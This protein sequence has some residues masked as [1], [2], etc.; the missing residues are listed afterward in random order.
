[1]NAAH[2][3]Q[4]FDLKAPYPQL[5]TRM[6]DHS[7]A[8]WGINTF[9]PKQTNGLWNLPILSFSEGPHWQ[10]MD[11][12]E[13]TLENLG[14][15]VNKIFGQDG[16]DSARTE[17]KKNKGNDEQVWELFNEDNYCWFGDG[18]SGL[19][20]IYTDGFGWGLQN[21]D[22][23]LLAD[24]WGALQ[25]VNQSTTQ[26]DALV[27]VKNAVCDRKEKDQAA[28]IGKTIADLL[29]NGLVFAAKFEGGLA[30]SVS[31]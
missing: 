3:G 19:V 18:L 24:I 26:H 29:I 22:D 14:D 6:K 9:S 25:I 1:M 8:V 30:F 13:D 5:W 20:N 7:A 27:A 2:M 28:D 10:G 31:Q 23:Q 12:L 4:T 21:E 16:E 11:K 15:K 17:W